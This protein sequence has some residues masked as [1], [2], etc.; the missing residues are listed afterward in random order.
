[1]RINVLRG[2]SRLDKDE[3]GK[4]LWHLYRSFGLEFEL[5]STEI[6][7]AMQSCNQPLGQEMA[8]WLRQQGWRVSWYALPAP[9]DESPISCGFDVSEDCPMLK[10]W[11]LTKA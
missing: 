10:A 9:P 6:H 8:R 2:R 1:M 11:R 4:L 7:K 5:V 3:K